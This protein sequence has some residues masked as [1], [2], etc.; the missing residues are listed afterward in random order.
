[1]KMPKIYLD[2][3]LYSG[4]DEEQWKKLLNPNLLPGLLPIG[5]VIIPAVYGSSFRFRVDGA[6]I[7]NDYYCESIVYTCKKHFHFF[8]S[9]SK[10]RKELKHAGFLEATDFWNKQN[11]R[12]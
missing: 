9:K 10:V 2:V 3:V 5:Y 11:E 4:K 6:R 12:G 8:E 1:M 7:V